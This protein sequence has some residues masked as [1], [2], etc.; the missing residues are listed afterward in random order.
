MIRTALPAFTR[1]RAPIPTASRYLPLYLHLLSLPRRSALISSAQGGAQGVSQCGEERW[2]AGKRAKAGVLEEGRGIVNGDIDGVGDAKDAGMENTVVFLGATGLVDMLIPG[3]Y[4][5]VEV[6]VPGC[7]HACQRK[8][9]HL[10]SRS[11]SI[12]CDS[13]NALNH[14]ESCCRS[15]FPFANTLSNL[16]SAL[17][18]PLPAHSHPHPLLS[19]FPHSSPYPAP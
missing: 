17:I 1:A 16:S 10:A 6:S 3:Q 14:A 18:V 2:E 7:H 8:A 15:F 13:F 5:A 4:V 9:F 19:S 12:A 11:S